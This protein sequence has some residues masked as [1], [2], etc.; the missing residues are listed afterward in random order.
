MFIKKKIYLTLFYVKTIPIVTSI[1]S[2]FMY[3]RSLWTEELLKQR[4]T[5]PTGPALH[6]QL[7]VGSMTVRV[8]D[9]VAP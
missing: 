6:D 9:L 4:S 8:A 3:E 2:P 5:L 1:C 7:Y